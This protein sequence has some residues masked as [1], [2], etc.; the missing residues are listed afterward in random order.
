M[1]DD[2]GGF[3][4]THHFKRNLG[5]GY[6]LYP[7]SLEHANELGR[8]PVGAGP[9]H[10]A[11]SLQAANATNWFSGGLCPRLTTHT[12]HKIV[13]SLGHTFGS[14]LRPILTAIWSQRGQLMGSE[15]P[16]WAHTPRGPGAVLPAPS[17]PSGPHIPEAGLGSTL[18]R[19]QGSSLHA[20]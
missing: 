19:G 17:A 4:P 14:T 16:L 10:P 2:R 12:Y 8:R 15:R 6:I 1:G 13:P 9:M 3:A 5:V 18:D 7:G 11:L 20:P